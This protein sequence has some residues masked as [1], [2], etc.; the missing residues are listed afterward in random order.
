LCTPYIRDFY[1]KQKATVAHARD[2]P[3]E[4]EDS[5]LSNEDITVEGTGKIHPRTCH[6]DANGE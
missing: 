5:E 2:I 1:G 3:S 4:I 6:E